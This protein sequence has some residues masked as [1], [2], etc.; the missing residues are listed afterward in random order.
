MS[1]QISQDESSGSGS[2]HPFVKAAAVVA[3]GA[4]VGARARMGS[5]LVLAGLAS[6]LVASRRK[7]I[8]ETPLAP[9]LALPPLPSAESLI[10]LCEPSAPFMEK[11]CLTR[12]LEEIRSALIPPP[13]LFKPP[14]PASTS[15]LPPESSLLKSAPVFIE[16]PEPSVGEPPAGKAVLPDTITIPVTPDPSPSMLAE[17]CM[18][19][20]APSALPPM[21]V[22]KAG[23]HSTEASQA[24]KN[25]QQPSPPK[26]RKNLLEWLRE[27]RG[28][29]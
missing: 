23:L 18:P 9:A 29:E 20:Q 21:V 14:P 26:P 8:P 24:E 13:S 6:W 7:K 16:V 10:G 2:P 5:A 1:H 12:S 11:E 28:I 15:T 25:L 4:L 17:S 27:G 22:P 19:N 3:V